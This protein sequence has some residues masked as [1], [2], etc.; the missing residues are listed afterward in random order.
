MRDMIFLD[1]WRFDNPE[2]RTYL[3]FPGTTRSHSRIDFLVSVGLPSKVENCFYGD[4]FILDHAPCGLV[5]KDNE[6]KSTTFSGHFQHKWLQDDKLIKYLDKH[7]Y[8]Y[9]QTNST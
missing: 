4:I 6:L 7:I 8:K 1:I 5:Y 9:L 3:C 2:T